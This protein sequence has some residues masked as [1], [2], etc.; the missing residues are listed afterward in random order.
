MTLSQLDDVA[1]GVIVFLE[2]KYPVTPILSVAVRI[3]PQPE[4][5][6]PLGAEVSAPVF[7][8]LSLEEVDML[9]A[10]SRNQA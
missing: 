10:T 3:M 4:V 6:E 8:I 2:R 9:P 5:I 1:E 7:V